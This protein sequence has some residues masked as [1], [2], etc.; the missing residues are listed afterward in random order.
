MALLV[1]M[2]LSINKHLILCIHTEMRMMLKIRTGKLDVLRFFC[3]ASTSCV[4]NCTLFDFLQ[5]LPPFQNSCSLLTFLGQIAFFV[6]IKYRCFFSSVGCIKFLESYY[7][8]LVTKRRQIGCICGHAVY[9]IDESQIISIP[10][11]SVQTE[12]AFSK[13]EL[14]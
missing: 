7:L 12:A 11:A 8:I 1:Y 2:N 5:V 9:S 13:T 4:P 14:R 3:V 6:S 10:H